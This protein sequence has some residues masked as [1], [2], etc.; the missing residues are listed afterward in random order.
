MPGFALIQLGAF[1]ASES[2]LVEA[3]A[4]AERLGLSTVVNRAKLH[5]GQFYSR[6]LRTEESIR[7]LTEAAEGFAAQRDPVGEGLARTV[8]RG[9]AC[10]SVASTRRLRA[11]RRPRSRS[12]TARRR[13]ARARSG[14]SR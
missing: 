2:M 13:I 9:R 14:S 10:T 12:S 11:R 8:S 3:I 5:L 1:A 4:S 7:T 6:S